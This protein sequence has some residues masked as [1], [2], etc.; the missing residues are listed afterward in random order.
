MKPKIGGTLNLF[1]SENGKLQLLR[2]LEDDIMEYQAGLV[3]RPCLWGSGYPRIGQTAVGE[4]EFNLGPHLL[5][6][7]LSRGERCT[8]DR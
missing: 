4:L 3:R 7:S 2:S 5:L 6:I 8:E 1:C